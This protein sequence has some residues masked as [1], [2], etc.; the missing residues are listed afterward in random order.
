[1]INEYLHAAMHRATY[2]F[3]P[4]DKIYYGEIAGFDGIY[5]TAPNL[6]DCREELLSMIECWILISV[7]KNL[8]IPVLDSLSLEFKKWLDGKLWAN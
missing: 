4:E 3:L 5:A 1:M 8:P 6:E 7:S 2:E